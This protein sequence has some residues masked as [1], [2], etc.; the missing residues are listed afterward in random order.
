MVVGC[1]EAP[2]TL[3]SPEFGENLFPLGGDFELVEFH[4]LLYPKLNNH[5]LISSG[6][7]EFGEHGLFET[8][9]NHLINVA[10]GEKVILSSSFLNQIHQNSLNYKKLINIADAG[11]DCLNCY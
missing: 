11:L 2:A 9:L 1:S 6:E 10:D 3:N 7:G 4:N 8:S 5:F